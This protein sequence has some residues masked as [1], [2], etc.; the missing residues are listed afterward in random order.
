MCVA[1]LALPHPTPQLPF[2]HYYIFFPLLC[3]PIPTTNFHMKLSSDANVRF[4]RAV[5]FFRAH[6]SLHREILEKNRNQSDP[7]LHLE[8]Q[9][10]FLARE[11]LSSPRSTLRLRH[12]IPSEARLYP[13]SIVIFRPCRRRRPQW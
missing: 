6:T 4:N 5:D 13:G 1:V 12:L 8:A 10:K 11:K 3:S 9:Q 2:I 7:D